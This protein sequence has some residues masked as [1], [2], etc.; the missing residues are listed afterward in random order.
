MPRFSTT[1]TIAAAPDA[2]WA[3]L[4]DAPG[5]P[6][7]NP[8]VERVD[9]A[10]VPGGRITVRAR[11]NPGRAFPVKVT[12]F[13]PP[14]RMVWTGGMPLGLFRGARTF[15][16]TP[17]GGSV[18]FSMEEVYDG[19]LAPLL[20]RTIPDLQPAFDA[21]AAALKERAERR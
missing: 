4:T 9:G 5:Y 21:F 7:W 14:A 8:T 16:L 15:T 17:E 2:V 11:I 6:T 18:R 3:L 20:G 12:A 1:T 19:P 10:I 13:E